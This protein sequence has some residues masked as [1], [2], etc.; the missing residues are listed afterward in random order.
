MEFKEKWYA[1]YT[2]PKGISTYVSSEFCDPAPEEGILVLL[3]LWSRAHPKESGRAGREVSNIRRKVGDGAEHRFLGQE[4]DRHC[5]GGGGGGTWLLL[6]PD[7]TLAPLAI[8]ET[9]RRLLERSDPESRNFPA[10][11]WDHSYVDPG[12][13]ELKILLGRAWFFGQH[14]FSVD[15]NPLEYSE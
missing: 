7:S 6:L 5:W 9:P 10:G 14:N 12:F 11:H 15:I 2:F 13:L 4:T 8:G 1:Q 3:P